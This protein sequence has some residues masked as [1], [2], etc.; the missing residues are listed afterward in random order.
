M[1]GVSAPQGYDLSPDAAEFFVGSR[2]ERLART[3]P[4]SN[5]ANLVSPLCG[6]QVRQGTQLVLVRPR[7]T[8]PRVVESRMFA[9]F[10][11]FNNASV[12]IAGDSR[13][14]L[15]VQSPRDLQARV[16]GMRTYA[17][18]RGLAFD[19]QASRDRRERLGFDFEVDGDRGAVA[20]SGFVRWRAGAPGSRGD[21][22]ISGRLAA[23]SGGWRA[24]DF[25]SAWC[26]PGGAVGWRS[27]A[28]IG[29]VAWLV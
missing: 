20:E 18:F 22:R 11:F 24:G 3:S 27:A 29:G 19:A 8:D 12:E 6:F 28:V 17:P 15:A 7:A 26:G 25:G 13:I 5:A 4:T 14:F 10:R 1:A 21:A 2:D 9:Q 23:A 16:I